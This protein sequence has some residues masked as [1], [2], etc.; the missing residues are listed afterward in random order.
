MVDTQELVPPPRSPLDL[1]FEFGSEITHAYTD[2]L[3]KLKTAV[4][5][6][7]VNPLMLSQFEISARVLSREKV[8]PVEDLNISLTELRSQVEHTK[9]G[10]LPEDSFDK[11]LDS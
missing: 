5:P 8:A 1:D 3:H 7:F 11:F 9:D 6:K 10:A 2:L 4:D